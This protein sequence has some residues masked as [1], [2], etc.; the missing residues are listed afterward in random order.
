MDIT[1]RRGKAKCESY[2]KVFAI[3]VEL[4]VNIAIMHFVGSTTFGSN[5]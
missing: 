4:W 1:L 5:P 2:F 3:A